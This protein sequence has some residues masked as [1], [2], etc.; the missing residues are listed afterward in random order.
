V[1]L[2]LL[3]KLVAA[4]A[5]AEIAVPVTPAGEFEPLFA[6]YTKAVIP[7]IEAL[8]NARER[9]LLPL[10]K[11]CRTVSLPLKD[12][13]W[14]RNLNTRRDYEDYLKWLQSRQRASGR[15]ERKSRSFGKN[16]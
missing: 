1:N 4:A 5:E 14:L 3:R 13:S 10:F 12:A 11:R 16:P 7:R 9:S 8:L 15:G 6:V 2:P